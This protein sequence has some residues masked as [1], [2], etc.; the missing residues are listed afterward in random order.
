M[1][2]PLAQTRPN[3]MKR[4]FFDIFRRH[5]KPTIDELGVAPAPTGPSQYET[6]QTASGITR[7][8]SEG[9]TEYQPPTTEPAHAEP[10]KAEPAPSETN[11]SMDSTVTPSITGISEGERVVGYVERVLDAVKQR[12]RARR[13]LFVKFIVAWLVAYGLVTGEFPWFIVKIWNWVNTML[14]ENGWISSTPLN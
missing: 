11:N 9:W 6:R 3:L 12:D 1:Q 7:S 8:D 2:T 5:R 13:W 4:W 14:A 10:T